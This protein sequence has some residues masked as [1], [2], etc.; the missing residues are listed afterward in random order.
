MSGEKKHVE[1][2]S[3]DDDVIPPP[4]E[5]KRIG[6][7]LQHRQMLYLQELNSNIERVLTKEQQAKYCLIFGNHV[8]GTYDTEEAAKTAQD[9]DFR[10]LSTVMYIPKTK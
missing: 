8:V 3:D 6:L 1:L 9:N 2:H 10:N 7:S 5:L 4:P